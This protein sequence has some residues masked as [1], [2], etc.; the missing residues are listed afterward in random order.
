V[1]GAARGVLAAAACLL[2]V[3]PQALAAGAA[4]DDPQ[5]RAAL[6]PEAAAVAPGRPFRVALALATAPGWHTYWRNPGDSGAPTDIEWQ[7]PEGALAGPIEWPAPQ[8]LPLGEMVNYGYEGEVLLPVSLT[9]PADL[10]PGDR[11]RATAVAYWVACAHICVA[12]DAELP[13]DLPVAAAP[14]PGPDAAAVAAAV[15]AL[16]ARR[17]PLEGQL[18]AVEGLLAV[19]LDGVADYRLPVFL[20]DDP[21]VLVHAAPQAVE[22]RGAAIRL[23]LTPAPELAAAPEA[24]SGLLLDLAGEGAPR[25]VSARR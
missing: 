9:P 20:P 19:K 21:A 12:G 25:L 17:P 14:A 7:L 5:A 24:L 4:G 18:V 3:L 2:A 6:R 22:R 11:F 16:P 15:A 1:R 10:R 13:L 23:R 8:V